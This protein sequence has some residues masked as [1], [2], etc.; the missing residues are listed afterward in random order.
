GGVTVLSP[1]GMAREAIALGLAQEEFQGRFYANDASPGIAL[2][3]PK[4]L[5]DTA[6]ERLRSTFE[7]RHQGLPHKHRMT[8]LEE[9]MDLKQVGM[10]LKDAETLER[11]KFT[12]AQIASLY[13]IPP[14]MIGDTERSTSWGTGIDS[15]SQGFGTY[16]LRPWLVRDEKAI[17]Q[18]LVPREERKEIFA[19]YLMDGLLRGDLKTR[20]ESYR[21][22]KEIGVYNSDDIAELEN[23]N[24]LP[25]GLGRKYYVPLNWV[26][27]TRT[28]Y[29]RR[30]EAGASAA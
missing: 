24:P 2:M 10:P 11:E 17:A 25:D 29:R 30:E 27:G 22:L 4:E 23:R 6:Y 3:H 20:T 5:S 14:H 18:K 16:T 7:K 28:P 26:P 12:R 19:E 13:R 8:I 15:Q 21:T 9:G 1:I